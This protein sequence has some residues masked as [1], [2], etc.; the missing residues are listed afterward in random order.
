[1]VKI[2][3]IM[4]LYNAAKY[5]EECL[6][7]VLCQTFTEFE[8]ICVDDASTD[9]TMDILQD[10]Q[11][12]DSRITILSN[13]QRCGAAFSRNRGMNHAKGKYLTFLDGDDVFDKIMLDRA[14][15]TIEEKQADIVIYEY[16]HVPSDFIHNKL[17]VYH[18]KEYVDRYCKNTFS[19]QT[20][21]AYEYILWNS[22]PWNKLYKR[23][24]IE[25]TQ[26]TF[27]DL[28]SSNDVYFVMMA[29][30][31]SERTVVLENDKVMVY[32]RDHSEK[33]RISSNRDPMCAYKALMRIGEELVRRNKFEEL[34]GYFFYRAFTTLR[35]AL[36]A[37]KNAERAEAFYAFL[38]KEGMKK[39]CGLNE[40]CYEMA[41]QFI[42]RELEQ[43]I[44]KSYESGW[45]KEEIP[46]KIYLHNKKNMVVNLFEECKMAKKK[47]A[48]WGAGINGNIL[49]AFCQTCKLEIEA[50]IDKSK[51][52]QGNTLQGYTIVSPEEAL[53]KIQVIV[54]SACFIYESVVREVGNREIEVVD[55]NRFLCLI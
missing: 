38:R 12:E 15:Q 29:L 22:A 14:Y 16:K 20:C 45:Y 24:F 40:Q 3:I 37:D 39:L 27:Q 42:Q 51:E 21:R 41:D 36:L 10:F 53:D 25:G 6:R 47:V 35:S 43:F 23:T 52:K 34:Y 17:E 13:E 2:S 44:E 4:P 46:L 55:I 18:S 49:L 26:L 19:V 5:L 32:V 30:M 33:G 8:L 28:S 1:M 31:L 50:V 54:I 11:R 9:A 7:S 48:V